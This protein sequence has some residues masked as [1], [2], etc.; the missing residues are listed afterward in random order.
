MASRAVLLYVLLCSVNLTCGCSLGQSVDGA[1]HDNVFDAVRDSVGRN[2]CSTS[3]LTGYYW[4]SERMSQNRMPPNPNFIG[5]LFLDKGNQRSGRDV[6]VRSPVTL[7][8]DSE[9]TE[10]YGTYDRNAR[11]A[12]VTICYHLR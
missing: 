7:A 1:M 11:K 10:V 5:F 12:N 6:F 9:Q 8:N 4:V 2:G 3:G